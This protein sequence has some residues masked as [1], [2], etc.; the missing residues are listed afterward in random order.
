MTLR[1]LIDADGG[2]TYTSPAGPS[3]TDHWEA[4]LGLSPIGRTHPPSLKN[5][6][7]T[8]VPTAVKGWQPGAKKSDRQAALKDLA[9]IH[10]RTLNQIGRPNV[11]IGTNYPVYPS[12]WTNL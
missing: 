2:I 4:L 6:Q 10:Q 11:A 3:G 5:P 12:I 8:K 1:Q 9:T 7:K